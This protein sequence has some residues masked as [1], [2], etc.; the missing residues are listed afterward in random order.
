MFHRTRLPLLLP[1][2]ALAACSTLTE[3]KDFCESDDQCVE[4]FGAGTTCEL[5]GFCIK[6]DELLAADI[7]SATNVPVVTSSSQPARIDTSVLTDR[8]R[9]LASCTEFEAKGNDGFFAVDMQLGQK[10]HFHASIVGEQANPAIYVLRSCDERTCQV[11]DAIDD[12]SDGSDE[13]LSFTAPATARYFIGIDSRESGGEVYDVLALAPV[14]GDGVLDHSETCDD[15]NVVPSDGCDELCRFE[16]SPAS[17]TMLTFELEPNDDFSS[18]NLALPEAAGSQVKVAGRLGGRCDFDMYAV[19]VLEG[20]SISAL[21]FENQGV[22]CDVDTPTFSMQL[23][24]S[25]GVRNI[26]DG[27]VKS[28]TCPS[29][30][31]TDSIA[32]GLSAGIYFIRLTTDPSNPATDYELHLQANPAP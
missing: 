10:W 2:L 17:P 21:L 29:L 32:T 27:T 18:A 23:L 19:N 8:V 11:G 31:G 7:C 6:P 12:C 30:D 4:A 20:G 24:D 5:N 14:C 13:H 15:G 3:E 25:S 1:I 28:G 9:D 26:G 22:A 16:L